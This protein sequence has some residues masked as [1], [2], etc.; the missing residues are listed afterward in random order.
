MA[1]YAEGQSGRADQAIPFLRWAGGKT[2]LL[3]KLLAHVPAKFKTYR[4]PFLGGGAMFFAL[5]PARAVLSDANREL[6]TT[7]QA[8][9]DNVDEVICRLH[10]FSERHSPEQFEEVRSA[11]FASGIPAHVAARMIYLNK[12][13]F[14]GLYRV[15]ASG[16]FNAP[17][18]KFK[19][20]P[21]ICDEKNLHACAVALASAWIEPWDFRTAIKAA[22]RGDFVYADPPYLPSSDTSEFT[23]FT[24]GGFAAEDHIELAQALLKSGARGAHILLSSA[25]NPNSRKIYRDLKRERITARRNISSKGDGR[26]AVGELLCTYK[27]PRR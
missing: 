23:S 22:K 7:Y 14:N 13:C 9:R 27:P 11:H 3:P 19:T 18:G 16:K 12:T 25:D 4:E 15:N 17:L 6:V 21:T 10:W 24:A 20:P 1:K 26:G 8:V 2:Q 5:R